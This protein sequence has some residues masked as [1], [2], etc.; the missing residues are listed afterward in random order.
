MNTLKSFTHWAAAALLAMVSAC[1]GGGGV[2]GYTPPPPPPT[3]NNSVVATPSTTSAIHVIAG[4]STP[5]SVTFTTDDG[6]TATNLSV[7]SS[8]LP[9]GWTGPATFT[10]A[11]VSTGSGCMLNLAY[12]PTVNGSG[13][14]TIDYTYTNNAGT[15]KSGMV[16]VSYAATAHN[17]VVAAASPSGQIAAITGSSHT[18]G[19]T[20]TTDNGQTATALSADLSGLPAGWSASK[21]TFTCA[22]VSSGSG[23]LVNLT[24]APTVIGSGTLKIN[25]SYVDNSGTAKTGSISIAYAA[26]SQNNVVATQTPAGQIALLIGA[27]QTVKIDFTTDDANPATGLSITPANLT[28]LPAGWTG[29][30]TFTCA[31]VTTGNGCELALNFHPTQAASGTITLNFAYTNNSGTAKTGSVNIAYVADSNNTVVGTAS[32]SGTVNAV[33]GT[34]SQTVTV[35]FNSSDG[36]P[37]SNLSVTGGLN[38]KPAGWGGPTAFTCASVNTGNGCQLTLTY[39]PLAADSGTLQLQFGYKSNS[40]AAK[41]GTVSIPYVATTS[42]NL[43]Y[44]VS[45]TAPISAVVNSPTTPVT[46]TFTTDDGNPATAIAITSGLGTLPA[47]WTGPANFNCATASTGTGCQLALNYAPTVNGSGTVS[48]GYSYNDDSGAAKTGTVSINYASIPGFLYVTDLTASVLRC[49]VSSTDGSLSSCTT[50]HTGFSA[51]TGIAFSGNWAYVAPGAVATDVDVCAV[52]TDGSFGTC[53]SAAT[54]GSPNALAVS[55]GRLYVAD[56]NGP[57]YVHSCDI[58]NTDGTLSNCNDNAVGPINTMDGVAV[59]ATTAYIVDINGNN[60]TTCTV[61]AVDG[62]LSACSQQSLNDTAPGGGNTPTAAPKSVT[63]YGGNLYIGT[64]AAILLLPINSDGSVTI[65]TSPATCQFPP[66]GNACTIDVVPQTPVASAAFNHGYA[67]VSGNGNSG[68]GGVG[69]CTVESSGLLDHC[70]TGTSPTTPVFYGG[71]A[72]H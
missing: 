45:P 55:G 61:S 32:P 11:S 3:T 49:A 24:Y 8:P 22:T 18:V 56:A 67:Y 50:A 48:L 72:V 6:K 1:G 26:T 69:V 62:T 7:S 13:T 20:F 40:G 64:T 2:G 43:V 39:T 63:A 21:S 57:G 30:A 42:D 37:G 38:P 70:T 15:S 31:T 71:L 17:N 36:N 14:L 16:S 41:T 68:N 44:T 58:N 46:V 60:L 66:S 10:C 28:S 9:A 54:F 51:P 59:T 19:V 65:P 4:S 52:N 47:G 12:A 5:Y 23:C 27:S 53:A 25:Y 35:T 33:V 29:P 34:G